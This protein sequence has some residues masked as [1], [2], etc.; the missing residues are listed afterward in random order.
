MTK[1]EA[2]KAWIY[3]V[4]YMMRRIE[5]KD[6]K[7]EEYG[8]VI[9]NLAREKE[10]TIYQIER[11]IAQLEGS[12]FDTRESVSTQLKMYLGSLEGSN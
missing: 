3:E 2:P 10:I 12:E 8:K 11:A 7:I 1:Q 6:A 9:D 5:S 4:A